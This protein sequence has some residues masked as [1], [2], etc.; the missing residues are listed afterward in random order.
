MQKDKD[1]RI[2]KKV[3]GVKKVINNIAIEKTPAR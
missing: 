1:A 2:A 3:K